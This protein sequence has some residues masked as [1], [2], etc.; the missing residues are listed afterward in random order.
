MS[1]RVWRGIEAHGWKGSRIVRAVGKVVIVKYT[2]VYV[3]TN[4]RS[5]K[6]REMKMKFWNY[7]NEC[8]MV[9]EME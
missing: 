8:M 2:W 1:P 7:M 6:G 9:I 3:C 4:V 5:K